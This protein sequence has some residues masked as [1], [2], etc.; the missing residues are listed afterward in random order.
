MTRTNLAVCFGPVIFSLNYG[1]KKKL[2]AASKIM[3]PQSLQPLPHPPLPLAT[4]TTPPSLNVN[5]VEDQ[6]KPIEVEKNSSL[7]VSM[8]PYRK[9]SEQIVKA[10]TLA[11]ES[12]S[13]K[14]SSMFETKPTGGLTGPRTIDYPGGKSLLSVP[15]SPL[16]DKSASPIAMTTS[17]LEQH[18]NQKHPTTN[19]KSNYKQ[20]LNKAANS[21]V[22]F[23]VS[24]ESASSSSVMTSMSKESMDSL[25]QLSKVV[26]M[27]VAD[28]IKY[29][30]DLFTVIEGG[31]IKKIETFDRL[32]E[33]FQGPDGEFRE[34]ETLGHIRV[35]AASARLFIRHANPKDQTT[36]VLHQQREHR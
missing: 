26:Q 23:A 35:R 18:N 10:Q 29:S 9:L 8:S 32:V 14:R 13:Q 27:C 21:I 28:M 36:R 2:K 25:D 34:T 4:P 17:Q 3:K 16:Q 20:K 30:M 24:G 22:N 33:S 31:F 7:G 12:S 15:N 5:T 11:P 1:N 19:L 6:P